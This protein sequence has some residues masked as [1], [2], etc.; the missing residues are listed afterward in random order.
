MEPG[1]ERDGGQIE[2][3]VGKNEWRWMLGRGERK[4]V[5]ETSSSTSYTA[6]TECSP[7]STEVFFGFSLEMFI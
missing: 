1:K 2:P 5:G 7:T 3:G 4:T 6:G